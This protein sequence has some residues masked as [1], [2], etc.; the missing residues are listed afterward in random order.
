[1]KNRGFLIAAL[2]FV[3]GVVVDLWSTLRLR[4]YAPLLEAN[5]LYAHIGFVGIA[6]LNA[7]ILCVAIFWYRKTFN[8]QRRYDILFFLLAI[9]FLRFFYVIPQNVA[10]G[11]KILAERPDLDELK[12]HV[13]SP[14]GQEEIWLVYV[15][16]YKD[17]FAMIVFACV[18]FWL[19]KMDHVVRVGDKPP[20][21]MP[22]ARPFCPASFVGRF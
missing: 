5:P 2:L 3:L 4:E 21:E 9:S 7:V 18:V 12:A 17:L 6:F 16:L 11:D 8:V 19:W 22:V 10:F 14:S 15:A 1:M 13:N 20:P